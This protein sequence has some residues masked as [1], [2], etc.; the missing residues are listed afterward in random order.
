MKSTAGQSSSALIGMTPPAAEQVVEDVAKES[1]GGIR[2]E[3]GAGG[4]NGRAGA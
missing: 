4:G 3:G 1:L 2:A